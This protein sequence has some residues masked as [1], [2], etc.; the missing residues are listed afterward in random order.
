MGE[1]EHLDGFR[2]VPILGHPHGLRCMSLRYRLVLRG[3]KQHLVWDQVSTWMIPSCRPDLCVVRMSLQGIKMLMRP[4]KRT[5][6][7]LRSSRLTYRLDSSGN[8]RTGMPMSLSES[9]QRRQFAAVRPSATM[10][11][12][13]TGKHYEISS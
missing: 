9:V 5:A 4:L 2:M 13:A 8:P 3:V 1:T 10:W 6:T 7:G 11:S 12:N